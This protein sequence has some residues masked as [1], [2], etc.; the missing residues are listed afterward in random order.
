MILYNRKPGEHTVASVVLPI[1]RYR[2]ANNTVIRRF[3]GTTPAETILL[4]TAIQEVLETLH[5]LMNSISRKGAKKW[6]ITMQ[7]L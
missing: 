3:R 5:W 7:L 4:N 1:Y 6:L 2:Q